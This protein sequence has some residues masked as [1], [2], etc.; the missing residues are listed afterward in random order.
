MTG[1]SDRSAD[2]TLRQWIADRTPPVPEAFSDYMQPAQPE[3]TAGVDALVAEARRA[4]DLALQGDVRERGGAF[5]LLAA[6]GFATWACEAALEQPH[7]DERLT[8]ILLAL[9]T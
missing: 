4:L 1:P 6:D 5:D 3:V 8:D 9:L 2:V 7:A